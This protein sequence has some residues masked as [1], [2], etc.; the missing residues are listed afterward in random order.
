VYFETGRFQLQQNS[1]YMSSAKLLLLMICQRT[2][3]QS[4]HSNNSWWI[5]FCDDH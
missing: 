4:L 5:L 1:Q 2:D 3:T